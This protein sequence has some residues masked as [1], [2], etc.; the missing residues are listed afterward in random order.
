MLEEN[1]ERWKLKMIADAI[2]QGMA[3]GMEQGVEQGKVKAA[4]EMLLKTLEFRFGTTPD[5]LTSI[6]SNISDYN[7]LCNLHA[8]LLTESSLQE[9]MNVIPRDVTKCEYNNCL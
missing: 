3:K 9:F 2:T 7:I 4:R 6:I 5:N 1:V 8:S